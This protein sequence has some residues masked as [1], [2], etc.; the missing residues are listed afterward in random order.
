MLVDRVSCEERIPEDVRT[1]FKELPETSSE[2]EIL[3]REVVARAV[4]DSF[5]STGLNDRDEHEVA[6]GSAIRWIRF[7][8]RDEDLIYD[9]T[10]TFFDIADVDLP[11]VRR[12]VNEHQHERR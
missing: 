4:M 8:F 10:E 1:I 6:M 12:A 5:G 9:T 3:F 11:A 7:G 2:D